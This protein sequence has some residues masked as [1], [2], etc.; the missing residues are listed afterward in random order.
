MSNDETNVAILG[1]SAKPEQYANMAQRLLMKQVYS[2]YPANPFYENIEGLPVFGN[3][4][5]GLFPPFG[6]KNTVL[7]NGQS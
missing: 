3:M 4:V 5:K 1:A 2:V 7:R 6:S